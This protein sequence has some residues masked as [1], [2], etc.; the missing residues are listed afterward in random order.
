MSMSD[1]DRIAYLAGDPDVVLPDEDRR[2]LD[3]VRAVLADPALWAEPPADLGDR[4]VAA[5]V[6]QTG[7]RAFI[8]T[9]GPVAGD[10]PDRRGR[11]MPIRLELLAAA[12]A[13]VV[14]VVVFAFGLGVILR[15][16]DGPDAE[17]RLAAP[18]GAST[19][20][21]GTAQVTRE[22]S[23]L[24]IQLEATGLPRR[25]GGDFYQAWLKND[26]GGL[27]PIGTFHTGEDVVLWAGVRLEDYPILSVTEETDDG[28]Q[29]SSGRVVLIGRLR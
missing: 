3:E 28:D 8:A 15:G 22:E 26:S 18:A 4:V 14:V 11:H 16:G 29:A 10:R 2:E 27:V 12:A 25:D 21:T 7:D 1:H 5:I 9:G 20:A 6:D 13:L 23:G 19:S 24:R 17:I